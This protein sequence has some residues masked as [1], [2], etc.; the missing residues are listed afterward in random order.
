[1]SKHVYTQ[2]RL[3]EYRVM[4]KDMVRQNMEA[5]K[6]L[7]NHRNASY[8]MWNLCESMREHLLLEQGVKTHTPN[9]TWREHP[10]YGTSKVAI[11]EAQARKAFES[12]C[13]QRPSNVSFWDW[14]DYNEGE[15]ETEWAEDVG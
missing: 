7:A 15:K 8:K 4:Y 2:R 12:G 9:P 13:E 10:G 1:M 5:N 11:T 3:D 6:A 14:W